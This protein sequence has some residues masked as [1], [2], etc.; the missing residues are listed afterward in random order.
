MIG[1]NREEI[2]VS[3]PSAET[4]GMEEQRPIDDEIVF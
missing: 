2:F 1:E 3:E 4:G